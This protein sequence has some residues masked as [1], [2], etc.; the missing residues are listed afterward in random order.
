MDHNLG[1][2]V[3]N[4]SR[5]A[6]GS[7]MMC[8]D[9]LLHRKCVLIVDSFSTKKWNIIRKTLANFGLQLVTHVGKISKLFE[10]YFA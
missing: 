3:P 10:A 2:S 6:W 7:A 8:L 1:K 5:S 9:F 4:Q